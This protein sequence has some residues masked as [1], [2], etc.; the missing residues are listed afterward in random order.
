MVI[1]TKHWEY[2]SLITQ[3][4]TTVNIFCINI[5]ESALNARI[6]TDTRTKNLNHDQKSYTTGP[7]TG[8]KSDSDLEPD[9][10]T[11]DNLSQF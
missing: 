10:K 6:W 11:P 7:E 1:Y 2:N 5:K 9:P 8:R 3:M 4:L